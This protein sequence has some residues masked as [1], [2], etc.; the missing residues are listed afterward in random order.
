[1]PDWIALAVL[2]GAGL[3]AGYMNTIAGAGS[4]LTLPALIFTGLDASG[5]NATN[6][7]A[8]LVQSAVSIV[9]YRR[10]GVSAPRRSFAVSLAATAAS[11]AGAWVAT[12]LDARAMQISIAVAMIAFALL[13][14]VPPKNRGEEKKDGEE[15]DAPPEELPFWSIAGFL[16]IGFYAGFLQAGVGIL[17]LLYLSL[18][19]GMSLVVSNAF[20]VLAV[21]IFTAAALAIFFWRGETLDLLRGAVLAVTTSTG[22]WLGARAAVKRGE[23]FVR[24]AVIAAVVASAG[25]LVWDVFAGG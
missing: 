16:V 8:V 24:F 14:L 23:R 4:L 19:H 3:V 2:A 20:K 15:K 13:S 6:R 1:M 18:V 9:A 12:L 25:K 11:A 22:A 5:A 7:I 17:I 10:N 21:T